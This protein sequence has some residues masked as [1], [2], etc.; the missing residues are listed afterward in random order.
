MLFWCI[1]CDA[2]DPT[3][4]PK[5][6]PVPL[7][8]SKNCVVCLKRPTEIMFRSCD[9]RICCHICAATIIME[10]LPCPECKALVTK[11]RWFIRKETEPQSPIHPETMNSILSD[12]SNCGICM[13]R[14]KEIIFRPCRHHI[15]CKNCAATLVMHQSPCPLCRTVITSWTVGLHQSS[16]VDVSP[17]TEPRTDRYRIP[18]LPLVTSLSL[19]R[20]EAAAGSP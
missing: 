4:Q 12:D 13:I 8:E 17:R 5:P 6:P 3:P 16:Y 15:C 10:R 7:V 14:K 11:W 9:H 18:T 19:D 2:D 1:C 20:E